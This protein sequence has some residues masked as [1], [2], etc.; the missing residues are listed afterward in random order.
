[1]KANIVLFFIFV[2]SSSLMAVISALED[3]L[4]VASYYGC[5][6]VGGRPFCWGY[7]SYFGGIRE[8]TNDYYVAEEAGEK[9]QPLPITGVAKIYCGTPSGDKIVRQCQICCIRAIDILRE[10]SKCDATLLDPKEVKREPLGT[11]IQSLRFSRLDERALFPPNG[12][13]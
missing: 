10:K 6:L 1:M 9:A 12:K 5:Y 2:L 11:L 8:S 4:C 3:Q 13:N 7:F